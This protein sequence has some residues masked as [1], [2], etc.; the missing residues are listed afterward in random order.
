MNGVIFE[1]KRGDEVRRLEVTSYRGSTF[2]QLRLWVRKDGELKPTPKGVTFSVDCL[3]DMYKAL[4][5]YFDG[6]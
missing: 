5:C 4:H 2:A 3:H 6:S 1:D